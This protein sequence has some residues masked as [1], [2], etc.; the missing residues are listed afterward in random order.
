MMVCH[1]KTMGIV[2]PF[3][4]YARHACNHTIL[5]ADLLFQNTTMG[6]DTPPLKYCASLYFD[7]PDTVLIAMM[8][9][10]VRSESMTNTFTM[11]AH[12]M[13]PLPHI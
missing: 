3:A 4:E 11:P 12:M 1:N 7:H 6:W 2:P 10:M 5:Y 9:D 8:L 13:H